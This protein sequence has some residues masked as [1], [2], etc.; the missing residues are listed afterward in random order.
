MSA[1]SPDHDNLQ[2]VTWLRRQVQKTTSA[3]RVAFVSSVLF[4]A[5]PFRWD[6]CR[7]LLLHVPGFTLKRSLT[8]M[9]DASIDKYARL[10]VLSQVCAPDR[11]YTL[12]PD[13][14]ILERCQLLSSW[15][16]IGR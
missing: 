13:R 6:P 10:L 4:N 16:Q 3:R 1:G 8:G 7:S 14:F 5:A 15:G 11:Q 12:A 2:L 9:K